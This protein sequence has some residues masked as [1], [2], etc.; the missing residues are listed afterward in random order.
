MVAC[1]LICDRQVTRAI[2]DLFSYPASGFGPNLIQ[3]PSEARIEVT[4]WT[5]ASRI[6]LFSSL[7]DRVENGAR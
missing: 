1:E 4:S 2:W 5:L 6:T 7:I 3:L